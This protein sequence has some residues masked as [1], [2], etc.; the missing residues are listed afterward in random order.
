MTRYITLYLDSM[1]G[2]MIELAKRDG[3]ITPWGETI[4]RVRNDIEKL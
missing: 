1:K 4:H 2:R 3:G